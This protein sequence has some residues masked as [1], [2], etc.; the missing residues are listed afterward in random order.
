MKKNCENN[1]QHYMYDSLITNNYSYKEDAKN[2]K[3]NNILNYYCTADPYRGAK[4]MISLFDGS[5]Q[6]RTPRKTPRNGVLCVL[7]S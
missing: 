5:K 3:S 6:S 7:P 2:D 1:D 4:H